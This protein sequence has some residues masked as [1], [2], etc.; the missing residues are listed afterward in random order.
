MRSGRTPFAA[1]ITAL[2]IL[3]C[4]LF[5]PAAS[6]QARRGGGNQPMAGVYKSRVEPH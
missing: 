4:P 3:T 1:V 2:L 5:T 6:A